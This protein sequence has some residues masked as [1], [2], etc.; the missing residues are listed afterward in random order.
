MSQ[1]HDRFKQH[2]VHQLLTD[3]RA[4][5]DSAKPELDDP[6]Q[7]AGYERFRRVLQHAKDIL[8]S[9]DPEL[10]TPV[11]L[12]AINAD[13]TSMK[14]YHDAFLSSKDWQHLN[15]PADQLLDHLHLLNYSDVGGNGRA[16][17]DA[18]DGFQRRAS[19][20]LHILGRDVQTLED[21]HQ[22]VDQRVLGIESALKA[23]EQQFEAQKGRI[24]T[25]INDQ[26]N[27]FTTRL[28]GYDAQVVVQQTR[29]DTLINEQLKQFTD[30]SDKRSKEFN[31]QDTRFE[32]A[33]T[34]RTKQIADRLSQINTDLAT[35]SK[36]SKESVDKIVSDERTRLSELLK[37][38]QRKSD[39]SLTSLKGRLDEAVRIV[40]LIGNTG[41]TG[42]Y[43]RVANDERKIADQFRWITIACMVL[44]VLCVAWI[45][46]HVTREDFNWQIALFRLVAAIAFGAPA[47]YCGHESGR[48]RQ[49]EQRNRRIELE[50]ASLSPYLAEL[51]DNERLRIVGELSREYFGHDDEKQDNEVIRKI[52]DLRGEDFLKLLETVGKVVKP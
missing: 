45:V 18:L 32:Q 19:E 30:R 4:A 10:V 42:N 24:D 34:A 16:V 44:M 49:I 25:L 51:P 26:Q 3:L 47:W 39:E 52:K 27:Q 48:H 46:V 7:M 6:A 17:S 2:S 50:L 40:G 22:Q 8:D 35:F 15:E 43:Q 37:E 36:E 29:I 38:H 21:K 33:E 28:A 11:A 13:L 20:Y 12:N 41:L 5:L 31:D 9:V 1:F 23:F 14:A